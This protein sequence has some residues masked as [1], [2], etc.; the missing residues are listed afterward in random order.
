MEAVDVAM[1]QGKDYSSPAV[2]L[3]IDPGRN[4]AKFYVKYQGN[5]TAVWTQIDKGA[6]MN[7]FQNSVSFENRAL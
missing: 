5:K 1:T 6:I 2:V 3:V 4:T 7:S